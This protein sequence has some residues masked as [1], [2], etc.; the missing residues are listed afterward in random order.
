MLPHNIGIKDGKA[1][2]FL[3][4]IYIYIYIYINLKDFN[5]E[6][7]EHVQILGKLIKLIEKTMVEPQRNEF[8]MSMVDAYERE[9]KN[10]Y[11]KVPC[12]PKKGDL[13][14]KAELLSLGEMNQNIFHEMVRR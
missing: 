12:L 8:L 9:K 6:D 1:N 2:T 13:L 7:F 5:L 10:I 11:F 4:S 3:S 14:R